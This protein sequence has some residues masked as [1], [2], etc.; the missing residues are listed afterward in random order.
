MIELG[1]YLNIAGYPAVPYK[2]TGLRM[3]ITYHTTKEDITNMLSL[4]AI[5]LDKAL[6]VHDSTRIDVFKAFMKKQLQ[7]SKGQVAANS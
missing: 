4:L 2:N 7:L 5:E 3:T 1:Y 6:K